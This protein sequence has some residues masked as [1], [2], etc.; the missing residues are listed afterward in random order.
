MARQPKGAKPDAVVAT[1]LTPAGDVLAQAT[2]FPSGP[3]LERTSFTLTADVEGSD[4]LIIGAEENP[5]SGANPDVEGSDPLMLAVATDR[6]AWGVRI[7]AP[8]FVAGDDAFTLPPGT[9]RRI[10]L[11]PIVPGTRF[12]GARLTALNLIGEASVAAPDVAA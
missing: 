3:P 8:G 6:L 7:V 2:H 11:R 12:A 4:P 10:A 1:L 9:V 5:C